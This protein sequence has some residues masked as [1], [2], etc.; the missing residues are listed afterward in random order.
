MF[1]VLQRNWIGFEVTRMAK[2]FLHIV[3]E[4]ELDA[5]REDFTDYQLTDPE[6]LPTEEKLDKY[7]GKVAQMT[8]CRSAKGQFA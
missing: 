8:T 5:L 2:Q 1:K 7:W 3:E 6:D 4:H